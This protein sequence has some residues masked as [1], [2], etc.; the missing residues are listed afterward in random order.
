MGFEQAARAG[1]SICMDD[2]V[3]PKSKKEILDASQHAVAEPRAELQ[4]PHRTHTPEDV[5]QDVTVGHHLPFGERRAS[6]RGGQDDTF[7]ESERV[8]QI[9]QRNVF[10]PAH[11]ADASCWIGV[12]LTVAGCTTKQPTESTLPLDMMRS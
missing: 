7:V 6:P 4:V 3:I 8:V 2:M 5:P 11:R 12:Q 1:I 10:D 9:G